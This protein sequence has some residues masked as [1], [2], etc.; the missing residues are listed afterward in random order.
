MNKQR[1]ICVGA[2]L[3]A[4]NFVRN[5]PKEIELIWVL[6]E[7]YQKS[8]SYLAKGG[9]AVSFPGDVEAHIEDT[10]LAGASVCDEQVVR[11]VIG[12]SEL[13]FSSLK[14]SGI[15][16]D[17]EAL[18][19]GGHS[20]ARIQHVSDQTGKF[21]IEHLWQ[22]VLKRRN[23]RLLFNYFACDIIHKK[24]AFKGLV[25]SHLIK[26]EQM[27]V[28]GSALVLATGG[29]GN[30]FSKNTNATTVNGSALGMAIRAGLQ[31]KNLEFVQFHPTKLFSPDNR[32]QVLVTE[33][34]RGAGA[35]LV[36]ESGYAFMDDIHPLGSLAP[37]DIV[38]LGMYN[39]MKKHGVSHVYLDYSALSNDEFKAKF[40]YLYQ[41]SSRSSWYKDKHMPVAPAAHYLC[42][43]LQV[44]ADCKTSMKDVYAIGEAA[45]TGLHGANRL[46]SNSLLELFY[47]SEKLAKNISLDMPTTAEKD[48]ILECLAPLSQ[49]DLATY[50]KQMQTIMWQSFGIVRTASGMHA[51]LSQLQELEFQLSKLA[52][53]SIP[54]RSL[55]HSLQAAICMAKSAYLRKQS[56]GC[57]VVEQENVCAM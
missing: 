19:E 56:L 14:K 20:Q 53:A 48:A 38:A 44:C 21:L 28:Y 30:L 23:T 42:G 9:V 41:Q 40:P 51:G 52:E 47:F 54:Y 36:N 39:Q 31:T 4:I 11:E 43:G 16:F 8:N 32:S 5:L 6:N 24:N 50:E 49:I 34:F 13:V 33:A 45:C 25:L 37:R 7:G 27:A 18:K 57:H 29:V 46:A 26:G 10:L 12:A 1:I 15:L 2:G 3:A 55:L 17:M 35:V 22:E